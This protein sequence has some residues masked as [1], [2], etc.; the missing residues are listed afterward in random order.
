M[1]DGETIP[2]RSYRLC[3]ELERRIHQI[4]RWRIPVPYGIPLRGI[5]YAACAL[6]AVLVAQGLPGI[7]LLIGAIHPAIRLVIAPVGAA[8]ALCRL[9]VDGRSAHAAGLAWL[10]YHARPK[11]V[12]A[13]RACSPL[14]PVALAD[15]WIAADERAARYRPG[16]VEG[17]AE[18]TLRYPASAR[19]R[20]AT[21]EIVGIGARPMWRGR[22]LALRAGQ[23]LKLR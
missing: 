21:V 18:V 23:R 19:R 4:D 13:L 11:R 12:A 10:G 17:P 20:G 9:K 22:R 3:F 6:V 1:A 16:V 8:Y 2:I 5:A 15:V 7:G 14:G